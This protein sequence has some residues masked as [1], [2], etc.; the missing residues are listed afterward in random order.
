VLEGK[1]KGLVYVAVSKE[2][3]TVSKELRL[4]GD[5]EG[6]KEAAALLAL[7]FLVETVQS[8]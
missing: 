5:R 4:R 1:E 7:K 6:N 2:D 8:T 3:L